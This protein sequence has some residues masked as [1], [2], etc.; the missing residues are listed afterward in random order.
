MNSKYQHT[1]EKLE[2]QL[3]K[4]S[5]SDKEELRQFYKKKISNTFNSNDFKKLN[6]NPQSVLDKVVNNLT[7]ET[8]KKAMK[9]IMPFL[10]VLGIK[11]GYDAT[12]KFLNSDAKIDSLTYNIIVCGVISAWISVLMTVVENKVWFQELDDLSS[13][14]YELFRYLNE[15]RKKLF[16]LISAALY[17]D[18]IKEYIKFFFESWWKMILWQ[19]SIAKK[20]AIYLI[21]FTCNMI[22]NIMIL[23]YL[24]KKG[25]A[26]SG[27]IKV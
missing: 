4:A 3:S 10:I 23:W 13:A 14:S 18:F 21:L 2:A 25:L 27:L 24:G 5:E 8:I 7:E 22:V 11:G 9:I 6:N 17:Y 19:L 12:K 1:Y 26:A 15:M 20:D 16:R